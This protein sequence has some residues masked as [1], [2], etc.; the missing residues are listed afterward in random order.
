M[1][2]IKGKVVVHIGLAKQR[3]NWFESRVESIKLDSDLRRQN[4]N[5]KET[6]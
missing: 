5:E 3:I 2:L 6:E 1:K 4:Y